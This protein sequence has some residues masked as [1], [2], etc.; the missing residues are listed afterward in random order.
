MKNSEGSKPYRR[1]VLLIGPQVPPYGGM[2]IQASLMQE[3][4]NQEGVSAAY[5][6][7]NL[8]FPKRL[9]FCERIRGL[10]PFLRSMV[11]CAELWKLSRRAEVVHI[12]ACSWLYFF[13]VVCPAVLIS[14]ARGKR[15]VLNYHGGQADQF[16]R[17]YAP[18]I[19]AFFRMAD[20]V[21]APS[22]FLV[23]VIGKRIGVPV[24]IVPNIV[25]FSAFAY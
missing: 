9:R 11:F 20:V 16:F 14:R 13:L 15:I 17:W 2:A 6:A 24:Q 25:D 4:M 7:S 18:V 5:L 23:E 10:R 1:E 22:W 19:R 12:L 3:L 8:P 21:T